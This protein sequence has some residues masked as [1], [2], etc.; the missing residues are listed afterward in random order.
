VIPP[1]AFKAG[2][3]TGGLRGL[4]ALYAI[5]TTKNDQVTRWLKYLTDYDRLYEFTTKI[6]RPVLNEKVMNNPEIQK[7]AIAKVSAIALQGGIDQTDFFR[8][9]VFWVSPLSDI[10]VQ[11]DTGRITPRQAA[12]NMID[13]IDALYAEAN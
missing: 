10:S 4:D 5:D 8:T 13:A 1:P 7:N 11:V 6:G 12:E 3:R 2:G 9:T